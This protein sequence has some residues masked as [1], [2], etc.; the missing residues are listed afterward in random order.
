MK[1]NLI[2]VSY[3]LLIS[4]V[5]STLY[6]NHEIVVISAFTCVTTG[7]IIAVSNTLN[8]ALNSY[9]DKIKLDLNQV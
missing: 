5:L 1:I 2:R 9:R 6:I 4:L 8:L 7:L 3:I